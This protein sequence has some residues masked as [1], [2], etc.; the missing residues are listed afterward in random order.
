MSDP[1][2][3]LAALCPAICD[4]VNAVLPEL[5]ECK[6]HEGKFSLEELKKSGLPAP[7]VKVSIL[8]AKQDPSLT[9]Y[10]ATYRLKMASYVVTKEGLGKPRDVAAATIC[11]VLLNLVPENDWG[12]DGIGRARAVS[13]HCLVSTKVKSKGVSLWAVT[14]DQPISFNEPLAAPLGVELYIGLVPEVG[15]AHEGDYDQAG[16]G[17]DE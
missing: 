2:Q 14:W 15:S 10:P 16:G 9:G 6:P 1:N 7:A 8:G 4:Q 13:M 17:T 12:L 11:Q 3:V 5:H